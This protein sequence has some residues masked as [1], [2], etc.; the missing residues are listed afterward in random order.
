MKKAILILFIF[1]FQ[2]NSFL[3]AQSLELV[4]QSR[5]FVQINTILNYNDDNWILG[6][7]SNSVEDDDWYFVSLDSNGIKLP[8]QNLFEYKNIDQITISEDGQWSNVLVKG[9]KT[10]LSRFYLTSL[11]IINGRHTLDEEGEEILKVISLSQNRVLVLGSKIVNSEKRA[12]VRVLAPFYTVAFEDYSTP[13]YFND[14]IR[15]NDNTFYVTGNIMGYGGREFNQ[16]YE[17]QGD[18]LQGLESDRIFKVGQTQGEG[19]F[20]LKNQTVTKVNSSLFNEGS[21]NFGSYGECIDMEVD[22]EFGYLL[23]QKV[24]EAPMVLKIN[25]DLELVNSFQVEDE[26]FIANDMSLSN[27]RIGIGGYLIP[28]IPDYT[29]PF[30]YPTTAGFFRTYSKDG[31]AKERELDLGI[32]DIKVEDYEKKYTCG[33]REI[34]NNYELNLKN[35]KVTLVNEGTKVINKAEIFIEAKGVGKCY[36]ADQTTPSYYHHKAEFD[37]LHLEPGDTASWR[38]S[39]FEFKFPQNIQDTTEVELCA[40][41]VSV[42]NERDVTHGNNYFCKEVTLEKGYVESPIVTPTEDNFII[43]PNPLDQ[44]MKVSLLNA[45]FEPT[46]IELYDFLGREV[47]QKYY[48]ASRAKYKEFDIAQIPS[49]FYYLR[50]SNDLFEEVVRVYVN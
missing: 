4:E 45:P 32:I 22:H 19:F 9:S 26:Y 18:I 50:I 16:D 17:N 42:E 15:L 33:P 20:L 36:T 23:F 3:Q 21:V 2:N 39:P 48:I 25:S 46:L 43:Y 44:V 5:Q 40:W 37:L 28:S 47:G 7:S 1:L 11:L 30:L 13:G 24:G 34:A 6:G 12:L 10:Y 31:M 14:Y 41:I 8:N 29:A 49:G 35:I 27:E 38:L